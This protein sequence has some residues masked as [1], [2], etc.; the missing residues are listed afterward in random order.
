VAEGREGGNIYCQKG[1]G[2]PRDRKY[3]KQTLGKTGAKGRGQ[4][5]NEREGPRL[6]SRSMKKEKP[7]VEFQKK[8]DKPKPAHL[9]KK[10]D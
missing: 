8:K 5:F 4:P 9:N 10:K 7:L 2:L 6:D 1:T 3:S